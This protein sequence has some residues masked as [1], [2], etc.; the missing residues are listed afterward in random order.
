MAYSHRNLFGRN[1]KLHVSLEKGQVDSTFRI[2]Y[3]DPW[4]EGDDKRTSRTMMVQVIFDLVCRSINDIFQWEPDQDSLVFFFRTQGLQV[5]SSMVVATWLLFGLQLVWNSTALSGQRGV[6]QQD[7]ISRYFSRTVS[8][9]W[10]FS[11]MHCRKVITP[12]K[13][14]NHF[15]MITTYDYNYSLLAQTPP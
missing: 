10:I 2:N 4:I 12:L 8:C 14:S 9:F 1:Q 3:T 5:H 6:V 11:L 7:F 15:L 13:S